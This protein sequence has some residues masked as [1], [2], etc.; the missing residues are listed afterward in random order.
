MVFRWIRGAG[1]TAG[2]VRSA[3]ARQMAAGRSAARGGVRGP[4]VAIRQAFHRLLNPFYNARR[5]VKTAQGQ[6]QN[7]TG[8]FGKK[9]EAQAAGAGVMVLPGQIAQ[10]TIRRRP[11]GGKVPGQPRIYRRYA[12]RRVGTDFA[13]S[14]LLYPTPFL[15]LIAGFIAD[16]DT[17]FIRY[18]LVHARMLWVLMLIPPIFPILSPVLWLYCWYLGFLAFSGK[19]HRVLF[20]TRYAERRGKIEAEPPPPIYPAY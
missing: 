12:G 7:L 15:P 9:S 20:L 3:P 2:A 10:P 6:A 19:Q 16:W 11:R 5:E 4:F 17:A 14:A 13:V 1:R 18:H 8:G